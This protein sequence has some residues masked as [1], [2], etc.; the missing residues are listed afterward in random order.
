[1]T[2]SAWDVE[3]ATPMLCANGYAK[4]WRGEDLTPEERE[5]LARQ[6][7]DRPLTGVAGNL[8]ADVMLGAIVVHRPQLFEALDALAEEAGRALGFRLLGWSVLE[9]YVS[10][11]V[12]AVTD[13]TFAG[14]T[15]EG[16][17]GEPVSDADAWAESEEGKRAVAALAPDG[18]PE[19]WSL[20]PPANPDHGCHPSRR[21]KGA[22]Q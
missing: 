1:M 5:A 9:Q 7:P 6:N 10:A 18:G 21:A 15:A 17:T 4:T 20:E 22:A 8:A 2:S 13:E 19:G 12:A 14:F 16:D 3:D 11:G